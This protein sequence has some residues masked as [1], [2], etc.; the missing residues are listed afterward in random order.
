M[1]WHCIF[2]NI[3]S[4]LS[5]S[6]YCQVP[7]IVYRLRK[8]NTWLDSLTY[9]HSPFSFRNRVIGVF[10]LWALALGLND[11][12]VDA[13]FVG[14]VLCRFSSHYFMQKKCL[15]WYVRAFVITIHNSNG[16]SS[17]HIQATYGADNTPSSH[18]LEMFFFFFR[19]FTAN[20]VEHKYK[21]I[22][23]YRLV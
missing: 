18:S 10:V 12:I 17:R 11:D 8:Y 2:S 9:H 15:L 14:V 22:F 1:L 4:M 20:N 21:N 5:C 19:R 13:W 7:W 23:Y 16:S 3:C 6:L